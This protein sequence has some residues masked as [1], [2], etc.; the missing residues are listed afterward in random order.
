MSL[1]ASLATLRSAAAAEASIT[2]AAS[3]SAE[4]AA[5]TEAAA[6][7]AGEAAAPAAEEAAALAARSAVPDR[8]LK[9]MDIEQ[10]RDVEGPCS[11]V[12]DVIGLDDD[13]AAP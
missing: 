4:D 7:A 12:D 8:C 10:G 6:Q 3:L 9:L 13:P 1:L 11:G 5:A 2:T